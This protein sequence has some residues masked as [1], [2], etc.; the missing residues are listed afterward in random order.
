[1]QDP[2]DLL[3][4]ALL[5]FAKEMR[6]RPEFTAGIV[7]VRALFR[8]IVADENISCPWRK[9]LFD[10]LARASISVP[11]NIA[12]GVGRGSFAQKVFFT[13]VA[14]GSIYEV[15]GLLCASP[16]P[17]PDDVMAAAKA[18]CAAIDKATTELLDAYN[19]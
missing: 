1:M 15:L 18:C 9:T 12:E 10:Q 4:S 14:R 16:V 8:W 3:N 6:S 7:L 17:V 5:G 11:T 2:T 19:R 13:R